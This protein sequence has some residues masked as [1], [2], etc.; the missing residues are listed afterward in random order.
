VVLAEVAVRHPDGPR[1]LRRLRKRREGAARADPGVKFGA[2]DPRAPEDRREAERR[3]ENLTG[4][5]LDKRLRELRVE[6]DRRAAERRT[7]GDRR[8]R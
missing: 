4:A 3:H 2:A 7:G 5:E 1:A 6:H 8:R